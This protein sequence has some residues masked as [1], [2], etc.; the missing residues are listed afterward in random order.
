MFQNSLDMRAA[1]KDLESAIGMEPRSQVLQVEVLQ[2]IVK[3]ALLQEG[4]CL[5]T[6]VDF[7]FVSGTIAF[8]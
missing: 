8:F 6:L 4:T 7:P 1:F 2:Y 5:F 3:S